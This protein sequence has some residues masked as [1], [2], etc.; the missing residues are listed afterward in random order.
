MQAHQSNFTQREP[1]Q[2]WRIHLKCMGKVK[3]IIHDP[4]AEHK[5]GRRIQRRGKQKEGHGN[6]GSNRRATYPGRGF[7]T[8]L[9]ERKA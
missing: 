6:Y 5:D 4:G 3:G 9:P 7:L 2:Q 1:K 8:D